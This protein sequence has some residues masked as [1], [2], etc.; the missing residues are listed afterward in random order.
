MADASGTRHRAAY[1]V[2]GSSSGEAARAVCAEVLS[3]VHGIALRDRAIGDRLWAIE[4]VAEA[5]DIGEK[6]FF[7]KRHNTLII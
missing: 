5:M 4:V 3:V 2:C 1:G 7:Y 6:S